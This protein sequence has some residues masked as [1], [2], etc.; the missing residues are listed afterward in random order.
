ML[1]PN[2]EKYLLTIPADKIVTIKPFDPKSIHVAIA[3]TSQIKNLYPN[4]DVL[5]LGASALGISG[6]GDLDIYVCCSP[7]EF[8][9]HL[10]ELKRVF[11]N[12]IK[13][14][15][16]V[17]WNFVQDGFPV[18]LYLTNCHHLSMQEQIRIFEVLKNNHDFLNEY[19]QLKQEMNG[20]PFRG[21]QKRK[22][23]FY[24]KIL[25]VEG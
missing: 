17:E 14:G 6:Q 16:F 22:Y 21:Y 3:I 18:E 24:N 12:P 5:F 11:G 9:K 8:P 13:E 25:D 2:Q 10:P 4:L 20:K 15:N 1:T 23:E 19:D 7:D